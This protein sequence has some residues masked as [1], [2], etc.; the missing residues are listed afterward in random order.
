MKKL[1]TMGAATVALIMAS[2]CGSSRNALQTSALE[3]DWNIMTVNGQKAEA[4]KAPYIGMDL[5]K[6][7]LYGCAGCN[8]IMG[9][10][11]IDS[12]QAGRLSFAQI[13][14]TRMLC[15]NMETERAVLEALDQVAEYEGTEEELTLTDDK[16]HALLTLSKRP[17]STLASLSGQWNI[18]Q[19]YG[20]A[21]DSIEKTDKRPF[22]EFDADKKTVHGNAGCNIVNGGFT[23]KEGLPASLEFGQ[24]ISTMMAGPGLQYESLFLKTLDEADNFA[25]VDGKLYLYDDNNVIAVFTPGANEE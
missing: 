10:L 2:S 9:S 3:G 24:L 22:L 18:A 6:K 19:V 5:Q 11:Q 13:G 1:K 20:Q 16:G 15:A 8:R 21:I 7:R 23:Q 4:E 14:S 17:A 25:I 12:L